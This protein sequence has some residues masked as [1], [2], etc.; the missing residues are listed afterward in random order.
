LACV[1]ACGRAQDLG[2]DLSGSTDASDDAGE[3]G[4]PS[5]DGAASGASKVVFVSSVAYF[6]DAIG[7]LSGGDAKCQQL[8]DTA[9]LKG[10]FKAWLSD[11]TTSAADRMTHAQVPY[12]L[13]DG[14]L[15]AR[16]WT[17]LTSGKL[18]HA[19]NLTETRSQPRNLDII[20][21]SVPVQAVWTGT[22]QDGKSRPGGSN[23]TGKSTFCNDWSLSTNQEV[24]TMGL[25]SQTFQDWTTWCSPGPGT[26]GCH[27]EGSIY[28]FEQ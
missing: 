13:R 20:C 1:A 25:A 18:Q 4:T 28:C 26:G 21:S 15:V 23:V 22:S 14:T 6:G 17:E 24:A 7:G 5:V 27:K 8:A 12:V 3:A 19:I 2:Y 11:S 10:T 16:D 9:G